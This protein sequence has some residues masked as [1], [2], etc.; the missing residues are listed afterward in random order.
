MVCVGGRGNSLNAP[1]R[2]A[3]IGGLYGLISL[4]YSVPAMN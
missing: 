3:A 4:M 2:I 1:R